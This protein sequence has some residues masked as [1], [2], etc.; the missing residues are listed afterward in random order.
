MEST[1][2]ARDLHQT[3]DRTLPESGEHELVV[4][5]TEDQLQEISGGLVMVAQY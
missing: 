4:T 3:A 2:Q 5:L 1:P